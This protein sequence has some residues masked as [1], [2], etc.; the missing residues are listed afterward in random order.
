MIPAML[1][2]GV[3]AQLFNAPLWPS[4]V[5][6]WLSTLWLFPRLPRQS[7]RQ[8]LVLFGVGA[9]LWAGAALRG[10]DYSLFNALVINQSLLIMFAGV[11]FLAM[12]ST[13]PESDTQ[14]KEGS[15]IGT[16]LGAHFFG[17]VI[18]LSVVFLLGGRMQREGRLDRAQTIVIGRGFT[19][20]AAWSPFFIAMGVALTYAP[21]LDYAGLL[22]WGI[23][24]AACLLLINYLDVIRKP[25][26]PFIGYPIDRPS[27]ML[28]GFLA[29]AVVAVHQLWPSLSIV[30]I[31]ALASPIFSFAFMSPGNR[32]LRVRRQFTR[33][34]PGLAPQFSLFLAAG[35]LSTGLTALLATLPEGMTLPISAFG[36][37]AAWLSLGVLV[38]L[39]FFGVHPLIGIAS[40]APLIAPLDPDPTLTGMI[41]LMSWALGTGSS[42]LS[43]SNLALGQSY[44]IKSKDFLVWNVPYAIAGWLICGG[45]LGLHALVI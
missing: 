24:T 31:I 37:L 27:M 34:L 1:V 6:A 14:P 12:A 26:K 18:N 8:A 28:P 30:A 38:A 45:V 10:T 35:V 17:A 3:A 23:L 39:S 9:L 16:L 40:L 2:I 19:A 44:G 42:P 41:F 5:L 4:A 33:G 32:R 15:L 20:A 29:A 36:H 22:P 21:G 25:Y 7:Q 11:S 13:V 43:G